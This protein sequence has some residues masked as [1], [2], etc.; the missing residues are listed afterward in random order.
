[1]TVVDKS[2]RVEKNGSIFLIEH[3]WEQGFSQFFWRYSKMINGLTWA[4]I[5]DKLKSKPNIKKLKNI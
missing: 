4:L 3:Y 5:S 2:I 1:M